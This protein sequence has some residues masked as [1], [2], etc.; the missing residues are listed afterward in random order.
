MAYGITK[1]TAKI[2]EYGK[3]SET[4]LPPLRHNNSASA[5]AMLPMMTLGIP[6]SP[7]TAVACG[8]GDL[9]LAARTVVVHGST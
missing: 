1:M 5:G 3:G 8:Y 4:E 7:T 6:G 9:G 2:K